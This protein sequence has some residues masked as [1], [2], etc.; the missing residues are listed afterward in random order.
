M[1]R[2]PMV[3]GNWKMFGS[4]QQIRSLLDLIKHDIH[5][6]SAI[7]TVVFPPFVYLSQVKD[8]LIHSPI[9]WGAQNCYL[10]TEG[11]FT[12]EVSATMLVDTGCHY[13]LVGHSERRSLF[14]EESSLVANKFKAAIQA[15]LK[16]ILCVGETQA[17]REQ[18]ETEHVIQTQIDTVIKL[19]GI[20]SFRQAIIAYEPVWAIGTGLTATPEQAQEIHAFIRTL[21]GQNN[22]D[23]AKTI[24]IIYGGSVKPD[25]A[26]SLFAMPDIDGGLVGGASLDAASFLGICEAAL[27][28]LALKI[29]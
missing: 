22:V 12:G 28:K 16:P 21:I 2:K 25:N 5:A 24:R 27:Q 15:G 14:H 10:G 26:A 3:A 7:D 1:M 4:L 9:E 19:A 20:A 29:H 18:G 8:L 11:A 13:V 17:Q 6:Y 23:I